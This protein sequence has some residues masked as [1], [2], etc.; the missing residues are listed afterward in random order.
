MK[1][2]MQRDNDNERANIEN[3]GDGVDD[4]QR[5]KKKSIK[6]GFKSALRGPGGK[7]RRSKGI[8]VHKQYFLLERHHGDGGNCF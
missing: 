1:V 4:R 7:I 5:G 6:T 8:H 2:R 3:H